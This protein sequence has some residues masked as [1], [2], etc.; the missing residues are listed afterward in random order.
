MSPRQFDPN[1]W[2]QVFLS[3][4]SGAARQLPTPD[5]SDDFDAATATDHAEAIADH[6]VIV[7]SERSWDQ[8]QD[9]WRLKAMSVE[10]VK[11]ARRS[12]PS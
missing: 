12:S 8:G 3:A 9:G 4:L 7:L 1:T 5:G 10:E 11:A 6:A 2:R